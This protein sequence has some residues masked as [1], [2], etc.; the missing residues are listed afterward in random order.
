MSNASTDADPASAQTQSELDKALQALR[1]CEQR[2]YELTEEL[3]HAHKLRD[4]ATLAGGIA[5]ET[6]NMMTVVLGYGSQLARELEPGDPRLGLLSEMTRA[7]ERTANMTS[8]RLMFSRRQTPRSEAIDLGQTLTGIEALIRRLVVK[9]CAIAFATEVA[10][11]PLVAH[12]DRN[13]LE[14]VILNLAINARDAMPNGGLLR[15]RADRLDLGAALTLQTGDR[16]AAGSYA[17]LTVEDSGQGMAPAVLGRVF[18]PFFTTKDRGKGT[19]LGLSVVQGIVAQSGGHIEAT[20]ELGHGTRLTL[21]LPRIDAPAAQRA[22]VSDE[23][24]KS[25]ELGATVLVV[26]DEPQI[27]NFAEYA[28]NRAGFTVLQAEDGAKALALLG[29]GTPVDLVLTDLTMPNMGG[30]ELAGH[31]A[32]L[33]PELPVVFMT[34]HPEELLPR[35]KGGRQALVVRKPFRSGELGRAARAALGLDG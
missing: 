23:I 3:S 4:V 2:N 29:Q 33:L 30:G 10:A 17:R 1:E 18:E 24:H 25:K 15:I 11:M 35:P 7:A 31:I 32:A 5:H 34:G 22:H 13:K 20:S 12:I 9:D 8:Q 27:R 26:D 28:L 16:L 6:N 21:Y 19:G 14:Q